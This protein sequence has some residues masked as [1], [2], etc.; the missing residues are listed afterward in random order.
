M[1]CTSKELIINPK[2]KNVYGILVLSSSDFLIGTV[3]KDIKEI[4]FKQKI[5]NQDRSE[6]IRSSRSSSKI[7]FMRM[8]IESQAKI[9]SYINT[10][11]E[12]IFIKENELKISGLIIAGIKNPLQRYLSHVL[13][14]STLNEYITTI[15]EVNYGGESGLN[16]AI[17]I[18]KLNENL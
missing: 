5:D 18:L 14:K 3:S 10:Q 11:L 7:R 15:I 2:I 6:R 17:N 12:K 16:E 13:N 8:F 4:N 9:V 1:K